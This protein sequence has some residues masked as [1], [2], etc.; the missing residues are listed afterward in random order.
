MRYL[1]CYK[2]SYNPTWVSIHVAGIV[3]FPAILFT[4][5]RVPSIKDTPVDMVLKSLKMLHLQ[6]TEVWRRWRT[7]I[8]IK[9]QS[10]QNVSF[11]EL[12]KTTIGHPCQV[13]FNT[14]IDKVPN[15]RVLMEWFW[16][17]FCKMYILNIKIQ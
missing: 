11:Q 17:D 6:E 3:G 2:C 13:V 1:L 15:C 4:S 7:D 5:A 16:E 12:L 9:L 14:Q 8:Q 10:W